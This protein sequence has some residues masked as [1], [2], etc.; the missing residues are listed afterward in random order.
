MPEDLDTLVPLQTAL[1]TRALELVRPGGVVVYA[2]CSPHVAETTGVVA[3]V[4]GG[5]EDLQV[6]ATQQLWPH[7]DGTDAMFMTVIR[8]IAS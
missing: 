2:T 6:E 3:A 1:L 7:I 8:R 5:R 4:M